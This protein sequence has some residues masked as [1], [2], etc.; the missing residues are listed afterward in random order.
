MPKNKPLQGCCHESVNFDF[1]QP[2]STPLEGIQ[3]TP[4]SSSCID[5]LS[6]IHKTKQTYVQKKSVSEPPGRDST[7]PPPSTRVWNPQF[8]ETCNLSRDMNLGTDNIEI[9]TWN[10]IYVQGAAPL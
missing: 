3:S 1:T 5:R 8:D 6:K 9:L 4:W 2:A 10:G 7:E